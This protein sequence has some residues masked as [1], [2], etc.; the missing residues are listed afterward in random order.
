M[1]VEESRKITLEAVRKE[2]DKKEM[3]TSDMLIIPDVHGR[4]FWKKCVDKYMDKVDEVVFLGDYLDP[5]DRERI[6]WEQALENFG[7][8]VALKKEHPHKVIL[9][10]GNHDLHYICDVAPSSRYNPAYAPLAGEIYTSNEAM[11]QLAHER[12][13]GGKKFLFTHAGVLKGWYEKH[14]QSIGE[15]SAENLNRLMSRSLCAALDETSAYRGGYDKYG[16]MVW[17]DV[18]EHI[19]ANITDREIEE[20]CQIFGHT[21]QQEGPVRQ[22]RFGC[23]DCRKGFILQ[24]DGTLEEA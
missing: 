11:F 13:M 21:Q 1:S 12:E 17:A 15:L 24:K 10:L 6:T 22:G 23:V 18:W 4:S 5:Y 8:I 7:E 19:D 14:R 3:E 20:Y 16:S 9:L 2:L